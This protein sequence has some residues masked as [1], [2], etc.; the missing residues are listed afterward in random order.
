MDRQHPRRGYGSVANSNLMGDSVLKTIALGFALMAALS[1][2]SQGGEAAPSTNEASARPAQGESLGSPLY[3]GA[4][5]SGLPV[6]ARDSFLDRERTIRLLDVVYGGTAAATGFIQHQGR[7]YSAKPMTA[8]RTGG[9][10]YLLIA[11]AQD[12][13]SHAA[14]GFTSAYVLSETGQTVQGA[15]PFFASGGDWGGQESW[16]AEPDVSV[17]PLPGD[18]VL[19]LLGQNYQQQ[20]YAFEWEDVIVVE[21]GTAKAAGRIE[22]FS[23]S[24]GASINNM[25]FE[26]ERL[27]GAELGADGRS[28][29]LQY[30]VLTFTGAELVPSGRTDTYRIDAQ[31]RQ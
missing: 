30:E 21:N 18:G 20:G 24:E 3:A 10:I 9:L 5:L 28:V 27:I 22:T 31:G 13:E 7:T 23:S 1:A 12:E 15:F 29:R 26:S 16:G 17:V 25:P 4:G 11:H 19:V 8:F 6:L 2:C 14:Q